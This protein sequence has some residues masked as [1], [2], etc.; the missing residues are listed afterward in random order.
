[1]KA[2]LCAAICV[3]LAA[4]VPLAGQDA[5]ED[6]VHADRPSREEVLRFL[7]LMQVRS[8]LTQITDDV[9]KNMKSGA[10]AAFRRQL[11]HATAEQMTKVDGLADAT[12]Q[13]FPTDDLID[14]MVPIYQRHL[15]KSDL[16]AIVT[17]YDSPAG[18]KLLQEQPAMMSEG[19]Q[20]DQ[21][22][23]LQKM[24]E[25]SKRLDAQVVQLANEEKKKNKPPN[26][27]APPDQ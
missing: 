4:A 7:D 8:R 9:K 21:D 13:E 14:A 26:R 15:T 16:D 3:M 2:I 24:G 10:E 17:F 5:V 18:K 19:M 20:A 6:A 27:A 11:P 22:I 1:M 25:L 12:S 23:M